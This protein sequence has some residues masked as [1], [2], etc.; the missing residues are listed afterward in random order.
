MES[1]ATTVTL[2][3][4]WPE[5][6]DEQESEA[7]QRINEAWLEILAFF[8]DL[9]ERIRAGAIS[10]DLVA[11]VIHRVVRRAM[12]P[13]VDGTEGVTQLTRTTGPFTQSLH[14]ESNDGAMYLRKRE[15]QLLA[16][17]RP[18]TSTVFSV[19]PRRGEAW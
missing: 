10:E 4:H 3:N 8:P 9:P 6:L 18:D 17:G 13:N 19:M 5:M 12:R 11:L 16:A 1:P 14:F 15:R 7:D 2:R